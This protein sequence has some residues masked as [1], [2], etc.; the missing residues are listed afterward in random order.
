MKEWVPVPGSTKAKLV[1]AALARFEEDGFEAASVVEIAAAAG[2]TTGALYHHFGSKQGLFDFVRL[3][4]QRR[5]RDRLEG[6]HAAIG[7]REGVVRGLLVAFDAAVSFRAARIL[8][9]PAP[10]DDDPLLS[11]LVAL[12]TPRT[13]TT[14]TVLLGAWRAALLAAAEGAPVDEAREALA[15]SLGGAQAM[16]TTGTPI[17]G[18]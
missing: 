15:W 4:M 1:E 10:T 16:E 6:A 12:L 11:T 3:E 2:A 5:V 9:E 14:A 7:G 13:P 18:P 8:G 17:I